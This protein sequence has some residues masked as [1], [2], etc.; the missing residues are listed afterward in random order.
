MITLQ[1]SKAKRSLRERDFT[2]EAI[3]SCWKA[4]KIEAGVVTSTHGPP[5]APVMNLPEVSILAYSTVL[6]N[7]VACLSP[8]FGDDFLTGCSSSPS[9]TSFRVFLALACA[10]LASCDRAVF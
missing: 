5:V 1:C 3:G 7:R 4:P 9:V 8:G 2:K 10:T 6:N